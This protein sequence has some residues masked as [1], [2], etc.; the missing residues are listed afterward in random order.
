MNQ[1][2]FN[3]IIL[4]VIIFFIIKQISPEPDSVLYILQKYVN[5]ISFK[6]IK[7]L[8][9][10]GI[11]KIENFIDVGTLNKL[12]NYKI[13]NPKIQNFKTKYDIE[14]INYY[15]KINPNV[16]ENDLL[17]LCCFLKKLKSN[18]VKSYFATQ[19]D[20]IARNF[21]KHE[22]IQIKNIILNK[23]N[24]TNFKF[25]DFIFKYIPK[26]YLNSNGKQ[27]DPFTFNINSDFGKIHFYI[28]I[29]IYNNISQ[30][31]EY[32]IINEIKPIKDKQVMFSDQNTSH[33]NIINEY[34][35]DE[36]IENNNEQF[37]YNNVDSENIDSE[38]ISQQ[39]NYNN[40]KLENVDKPF[41]YNNRNN[42]DD[43]LV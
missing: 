11:C 32:I 40:D 4:L 17:N 31:K 19:N 7:M 36:V 30:N 23:L 18:N 14:F 10:I 24:S 20:I 33:Y 2:I 3:N 42:Y 26:Y 12:F 5:Y 35:N 8:G 25:N 13:H 1:K 39:F 6:F 16:V 22:I 21:T 9:S 27:V 43:T 29:D 34:E 41:D 28:D 15:K 37:N 38:N